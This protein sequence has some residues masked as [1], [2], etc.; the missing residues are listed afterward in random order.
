M[1]DAKVIIAAIL[2]DKDV[3]GKVGALGELFGGVAG[4]AG[5]IG[6]ALGSI[7][8]Q[9][10]SIV[11]GLGGIGKVLGGATT[12]AGGLGGAIGALAGPAAI[13]V[14]AV[15]AIGA[16]IKYVGES[17]A[18]FA[19]FES[20][21]SQLEATTFA[22]TAQMEAME[23][24]AQQAGATTV[25]TAT[26]SAEAMNYLAQAGYDSQTIIGLLPQTLLL[27]QA[28]AMGLAEATDMA[29]GNINALGLGVTEVPAFFDAAA[30]SA[31]KTNSDVRDLLSAIRQLGALGRNAAGG[32]QELVTLMGILSNVGI[33]GAEAG[34]HLR[35]MMLSLTSPAKE[36]VELMEALNVTAG[37]AAG[38][39]R[40]IAEIIWDIGEATAGMTQVE[41][42]DVLGTI[43]NTRDLAA[44]TAILQTTR[45]EYAALMTEVQASSGTMAQMA[46]IQTD[47][48]SGLEAK[49][50]SVQEAVAIE[51]AKIFEDQKKGWLEYKIWLENLK[52]DALIMRNTNPIELIEMNAA[53]KWEMMRAN[54]MQKDLEQ[55][56]AYIEQGINPIL[57]MIPVDIQPEIMHTDGYLYNPDDF[58]SELM[59]ATAFIGE[60]FGDEGY[61]LTVPTALD[62]DI[63]RTSA[64][65]DRL[66]A[67]LKEA[68]GEGTTG[69]PSDL[70]GE[71]YWFEDPGFSTQIAA[72]MAGGLSAAIVSALDGLDIDGL[73]DDIKGVQGARISEIL[74]GALFSGD[75]E[76]ST[77]AQQKLADYIGKMFSA[78]ELEELLKTTDMAG[79]TDG[80]ISTLIGAITSGKL[81][82]VDTEALSILMGDLISKGLSGAGV[83]L[84]LN[85]KSEI[86]SSI[87]SSLEDVINNTVLT[88][89]PDL[90]LPEGALTDA[91]VTFE[92]LGKS[93]ADGI[94][95]G[96][97][98]G[99][100]AVSG[101]VVALM[102]KAFEA[103][104]K[105]T[106]SKSPS[107][108]FAR[109][110]GYVTQGFSVGIVNEFANVRRDIEGAFAQTGA[111]AAAGI[112]RSM[113]QMVDSAP[114]RLT[115]QIMPTGGGRGGT[116]ILQVD[117]RELARATV[118]DMFAEA[119]RKAILRRR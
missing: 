114:A 57:M 71:G 52:L 6:Q 49:L 80:L 72:Q 73:T 68:F 36:S 30:K 70:F 99:E 11:P 93:A 82:D 86:S 55:Y 56:Y 23:A 47:N 38:N 109:L 81:E 10:T 33:K 54:A 43:F 29:V 14:G 111:F 112:A 113:A 25:F 89:D 50:A 75:M 31:Q 67:A 116:F 35:N 37:D 63:M 64:T 94:A 98:A 103:G 17:M 53:M 60:M 69:T 107:K 101:A 7:L 88:V 5:G 106:E 32:Y 90:Q 46:D 119:D 79:L 91:E 118:D 62:F 27:A 65:A 83:G 58:K 28:G 8:P 1:A 48:I 40:P 21:M 61:T 84:S 41:Q 110:G 105:Y 16:A 13:A 18:T 87:K 15:T 22:T 115:P 24:A 34:T 3:T 12:A 76:V 85:S 42:M 92:P 39:L 77:E 100:G 9:I 117:G 2:N 96:I 45:N 104:M 59:A 44:A 51:T 26:Q 102:Q 97:T 95:A 108:L 4:Q 19:T 78:T 74:T 66:R 20:A